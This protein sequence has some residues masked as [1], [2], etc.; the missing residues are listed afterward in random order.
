MSKYWAGRPSI[1]W[2]AVGFGY[3]AIERGAML[4]VLVGL[5]V[6]LSGD[7]GFGFGGLRQ[8]R[9]VI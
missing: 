4:F 7:D 2:P 8:C 3:L 5:D 6:D 9:G 1:A